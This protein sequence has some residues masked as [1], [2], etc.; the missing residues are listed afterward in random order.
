MP[1]VDDSDAYEARLSKVS[2]DKPVR[3]SAK[4][5]LHSYDPAWL[6]LYSREQARIAHILEDRATRVE[7]VGSTSVPELPAKP[8]IDIV[9][10][11]ANSAD[12]QAYL[13]ELE[14][15]GYS[16]AVRESDWYEHRLLKG[17]DTNINLHVFSS[18]CEETERMVR[19]RDWLR[20]HPEDRDVYARA[21]QDLASHDW[22]FVQQ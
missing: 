4:I 5:E 3:L 6:D 21:K 8:I 17:P 15:A 13:P 14:A 2:I 20:T 19:F 22:Q 12:E 16:L 18:G 9:L 7:H 1:N 11:V 10:E